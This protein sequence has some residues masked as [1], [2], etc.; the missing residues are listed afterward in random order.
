MVAL[1]QHWYSSGYTTITESHLALLYYQVLKESFGCMASVTKT[2]SIDFCQSNICF[3][4]ILHRN[5]DHLIPVQL[6]TKA[7]CFT[8]HNLPHLDRQGEELI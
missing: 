8:D 6:K 7:K 3:L 5:R 1:V 2:V 4:F